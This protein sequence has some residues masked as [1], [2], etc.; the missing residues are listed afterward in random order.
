M[1]SKKSRG[2]T[3]RAERE[4]T[5]AQPSPAMH[6]T[7]HEQPGP[8]PCTQQDVSS[9]EATTTP[10]V[11]CARGTRAQLACRRVYPE[12]FRGH[13]ARKLSLV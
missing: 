9:Q 5:A 4:A 11:T 12:R 7:S 2:R 13:E 8:Q 1:S 6:C 3:N 10:T